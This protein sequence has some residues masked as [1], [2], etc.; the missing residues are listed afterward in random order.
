MTKRMSQWTPPAGR[1]SDRHDYRSAIAP[2]D[3]A[4]IGCTGL[5]AGGSARG[6]ARRGDYKSRT[7]IHLTSRSVSAVMSLLTRGHHQLRH[8]LLA[9]CPRQAASQ[10]PEDPPKNIF[11]A[12]DAP[13]HGLSQGDTC[14]GQ[15]DWFDREIVRYVLLWAPEGEVWDEDV[16][17]E[18]GMTVEQLVNRFHRIIDASVPGLGRL[19]K[20]DRDLV[21]KARRLPRIFGQA[22]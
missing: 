16:Y 18:F 14:V 5:G 22:R 21:D 8:V 19:A 10:F 6:V 9:I 17:P 20:S 12:Q 11:R 13:L 3:S 2:R 15:L 7:D 1:T 4:L